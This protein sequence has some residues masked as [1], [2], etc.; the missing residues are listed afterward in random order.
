MMRA[1]AVAISLLLSGTAAAQCQFSGGEIVNPTAPGCGNVI[2]RYTENTTGSN[3]IPLGYPVPVP[4]SSLTPV[5][6]FRTYDSLLARHQDLMLSN[7][8]VYGEVI[9][10]THSGRDI[11]GYRIGTPDTQTPY[12]HLKGAVMAIAGVHA[13]E[14]QPPEVITEIFERAVATSSDGG[15]GQ[16]LAENL[17]V[18]LVPVVNIDGFRQTQMFPDTVTA[19]EF[20]PRDGRMRRKNLHNPQNGGVVDNN[21]STVADNF[22]GV[23]INRNY[24][25]GFRSVAAN[26]SVTSLIHAG[27]SIQ[28][29]AESQAVINAVGLAPANRLRLF[30]DIHSFTQV[31]FPPMTGNAQRDTNTQLL[32]TRMRAV[33]GFKYGYSPSPPGANIGTHADHF[34]FAYQVPSWTLETEPLNGGSDYG[35]LAVSHS[36][37]ITPDDEIARVRDEL[38]QTALLGFYHQAGPPAVVAAEILD[39]DGDTVWRVDWEATGPSAREQVVSVNESLVPGADYTLR[40]SFNK[41][42]RWRVGGNV[43]QFPGQSVSLLPSF[44]LEIQPATGT[45]NT[46]V[47]L[48]GTTATWHEDPDDYLHYRDDTVSHTFTVPEALPDGPLQAVVV[49]NLT[50]LASL[51]LDGNPATPVDWVNGAWRNYEDVTL[52]DTFSGGPDCT[53]RLWIGEGDRGTHNLRCNARIAAEAAPPPPPPTPTPTP[54]PTPRSGGGAFDWFDLAALL[55]LCLVA[56]RYFRKSRVQLVA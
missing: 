40:V 51:Q 22:F 42:M 19:H 52:T 50:D 5:D 23:D 41:P 6:G 38:A 14:W 25:P 3:L 1:L 9:G 18:V 35:G 36:G 7:D 53:L 21:L 11:W 44:Q 13:R 4:V 46:V 34:A 49:V 55:L 20:Q 37:F 31:Y 27:S 8:E 15:V 32:A 45:N 26:S 48:S 10:V 16:Y 24:S 28:S 43:G 29:E 39:D 12:G 17:T 30:M 33:T 56:R 2:L 47:L 54:T